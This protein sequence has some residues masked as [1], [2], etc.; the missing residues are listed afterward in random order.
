MPQDLR[1]KSLS[2]DHE[3][4]GGR[5]FSDMYI[6]RGFSCN[7]SRGLPVSIS[8]EDS[9]MPLKADLSLVRSRK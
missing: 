4:E 8:G 7:Q 2:H 3:G 1:I 5:T 9:T 6:I